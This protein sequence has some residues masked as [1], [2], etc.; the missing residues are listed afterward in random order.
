MKMNQHRNLIPFLEWLPQYQKGWL[1]FDVIAGL[2][3][4]AVVIPK[5]MAY[6]S[7]VGLPLEVGLYSALIPMVIYAVL[8][9]SRTLSVSTTTTIAI[10][11][12]SQLS[13]VAPQGSPAE[14]MTAASTLAV[15]VGLIL[16]AASILR[17]GFIANFISDP[18]LTGF[19]AGIGIVIIVDQIPKLLG[20]HFTKGGFI[21]NLMSIVQ[22]LPQTS[23]VTLVLA[24]VMLVLILGLER[25]RPH[26]PAPLVAVAVGI[27]AS[28][29]L[30]LERF[31]VEIVG[32]IQP[33][34]PS[35]STPDLSLVSRLA[36]GALG[37]ALMSFTESIAAG[38]AFARHGEP[39]PNANKELL[40]LG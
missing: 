22:S 40:A 18:V 13:L 14:L 38:R 17:L 7:I 32:A 30:N 31:G 34:L 25:F 33:G 19:K 5:A 29:L 28:G 3:A 26:S 27:A 1:R 12:V 20:V 39:R 36:P 2:T 6:A 16:L 4:S 10:L 8:G 21:Q 15:L 37:I 23:L 35:F 9:T 24:I 11:T